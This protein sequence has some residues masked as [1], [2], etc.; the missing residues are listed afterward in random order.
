MHNRQFRNINSTRTFGGIAILL[1]CDLFH[2]FSI[3][4]LDKS[5]DGVFIV[6]LTE[7]ISKYS[8]ILIACYLPPERSP[9]GRDA[10]KF[11]GHILNCIHI[12]TNECDAI[13]LCGDLNSRLGNKQDYIK[14]IDDIKDR[15]I[16]DNTYNKHGE[17]FYEFLLDSKMCVLN[18]RVNS[19]CNDFTYVSSRGKSVVD[20]VVV[21]ITIIETCLSFTVTR[22]VQ[23]LQ[24]L[25]EASGQQPELLNIDHSLLTFVVSLNYDSQ[26]LLRSN[27]SPCAS[28][29][30][31]ILNQDHVPLH[32]YTRYKCDKVPENL[33]NNEISASKILDLIA[34]IEN[35]NG[36]QHSIDKLYD[37]LCNMYHDEMKRWFQCKNVHPSTKK[38]VK[39]IG[40]PFWNEQLQSLWNKMLVKEKLFIQAK[41]ASRTAH[42]LA[43]KTARKCFDREY[44]KEERKFRRSKE[45]EIETVCTSD[46]K[47]F[48]KLLKQLGPQKKASQIPM[49]VYDEQG[50]IVND[51]NLVFRKW[52]KDYESLYNP[53]INEEN[54][55]REFYDACLHDINVIDES[56]ESDSASDLNS[57]FTPEEVEKV[58]GKIKN[59][60]SIGID[61]LPHEILKNN[62]T[63]G[64]LTK[65]FNKVFEQN[66]M[67]TCWNIAI[68]KPIPKSSLLD[69]RIPLQYRG[70]SLLST[71]YKIYTSLLNKRL[72]A[73]IE[74]NNIYKDE[75]NGFRQKRSCAEH[76][77][78]LTSIIRNRKAQNKPTFVGYIDFEK[79]FD[80]VDRQLLIYKL[81]KY[82]VH[83]QML[84]SLC[85]VYNC[86]K[87]GV[88]LNGL[89]TNWFSIGKGV[90]QGDP[91]SP[92]LFGLFVNDLV[93]AIKQN[94]V[95]FKC[96]EFDVQC[97]L[98]AD[99]LALISEN[100]TDLQNMLDALN[101]W[102]YKWRMNINVKKSKIVHYRARNHAE[103]DF[104]FKLGGSIVEK[105]DSYKYL[106]LILDYSL[107]FNKTA[108]VLGD[109]GGRALGSVINKFISNKGL[110]YKAYTKLY[111][112]TVCPILDYCSGIWGYS[113]FET[114][115]TIQNRAIRFFLGVHKFAPNLGING[116]L[117]WETRGIRRKIEMIRLWNRLQRLDDSRL[118][119][120]VFKWDKR[121]CKK[122]WANDIRNICIETD[123]MVNFESN[124]Y[125][126]PNLLRD[127]L[128]S[129]FT[130]EWEREVCIVPKLRFY[131][132]FKNNYET[133]FYVS[134]IC[135]RSVRSLIAQLRLG[136][137][138]L[139]IETGRYQDIPIEYRFCT[140]CNQD[141]I[142]SEIHF[143]L[144]C[145]RYNDIRYELFNIARV[146]VPQIDILEPD[147]QIKHLMSNDL[148][149]NTATFVYNAFKIRRNATFV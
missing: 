121:L 107:D 70:I 31:L 147:D 142:E 117:G 148:I 129:L 4:E 141:S 131:N 53:C 73:Y 93:D 77:Y 42:R 120:K 113:K 57:M 124:L 68:I 115:D 132:I 23:L 46:P 74:N 24:Q 21:P 8:V 91:L 44:R 83:G 126:N 54:Y 103:T 95:G 20:Y 80:H 110:G 79:A 144:Y 65:F 135:N 32:Y 118:T 122:N 108:K 134:K 85:M 13:Y 39:R 33:F 72:L 149:S 140:Y 138:P 2:D 104:V 82:G 59:K 146:K 56:P 143:L 40:K 5:L 64:L 71:I 145:D 36:T 55:D 9:W 45:L 11:F 58:V 133:E 60:K 90:R 61:N 75:Q 30:N 114:I 127:R 6:K 1:K 139:C 3:T 62:T 87:A 16:L 17:A 18:G 84:K 89:I 101:E 7:K 22:P 49:E 102:C 28:D 105:V 38:R 100:E 88:E 34:D 47:Q 112:M 26:Q 130:T 116:E 81:S 97:L 52:Q 111:N 35:A 50:N 137:M 25:S 41:G 69:Y 48:W 125:I 98:F 99:D 19:E 27:V 12:Y 51:P 96:S 67:P 14:G 10:S 106:G 92:T 109:S 15:Q 86:A 123:L 76:I 66:V 136:I 43:F 119:K 63:V 94:S 128:S 29:P 78:T 37:S